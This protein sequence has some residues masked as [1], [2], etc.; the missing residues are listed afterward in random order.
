MTDDHTHDRNMLLVEFGQEIGSTLLENLTDGVYFVDRQRRIVYWNRG[1]ERIT[2]FDSGEVLAK[3]CRDGILEHCDD[4]GKT[5]CGD[6]CPLLA[7]MIDGQQREAHVYLHHKDGHRKP[8]R[9]SASPIRNPSGEIVGAIESFNEELGFGVPR[10]RVAHLLKA[11]L[12]DPLTGAGNRHYG[13]TLLGD[14]LEQHSRTRQLFGL[15][16]ADIDYL[17]S[18]NEAYGSRVGDEALRI[19]A[20]TFTDNIR[21]N[22]HV[23]RWGGNQFLVLLSNADAATLTVTAE[24]FRML[25]ARARLMADHRHVDLNVTIGGTLVAPGDSIERITERA[26]ALARQGKLAGRNRVV[27]DADPR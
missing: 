15:L 2:G 19:V 27:V 20:S 14:W 18:T 5:L 22:D 6:G 11:A 24:R 21:H 7:T 4:V 25:V 13:E 12:A 17:G 16:I 23:V 10:D 1:A 9:V 26:E 3:S 8:V